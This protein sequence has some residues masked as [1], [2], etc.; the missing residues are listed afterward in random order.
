MPG[1]HVG[2]RTGL[3]GGDAW[4]VPTQLSGTTAGSGSPSRSS[5]QDLKPA[6]MS[7]WTPRSVSPAAVS[8]RP[9]L[10]YTTEEL[11]VVI[12]YLRKDKEI[13]DGTAARLREM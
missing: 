3:V 1:E 8:P 5:V 7:S 12:R 13:T 9:H 6:R 2:R 11:L 4:G 10:T